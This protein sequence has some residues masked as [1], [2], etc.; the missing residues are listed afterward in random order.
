[1][2]EVLEKL[3]IPEVYLPIIYVFI[4]VIVNTIIKKIISKIVAKRQQNLSKTSYNYK[5]METFK[6]LLQNITK[7]III[8]FLVLSVLSVYGVNVT[9]ILA[10]LG[11]VGLVVGL[12]LQDLAKDI[13]AGFSII[14]ENQYAMGDVISIGDFKGEVIFLGLKTTKIKN[15]EGQVKIVA[16][17]N[18]TEVINYS[19][20]H[21]RAIVD[22]DVAYEENN[23]HVEKVLS[24]LAFELTEELPK[25]KGPVELLGI[26]ELS[27]SSVKYRMSAITTSMEHL[28]IERMMRKRI[29]EVLDKEKIKI[30]YTQIEVHNGK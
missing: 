11:I 26:Q 21:S 7:Y 29:K 13:I 20:E 10:G 15:Y 16:N 1:M 14:I 24:Q 4:A 22:I 5:K 2:L 3:V 17:R 25:L 19:M 30:P 27:T 23:E 12:A 9:S 28:N 8:I 6:V 18:A